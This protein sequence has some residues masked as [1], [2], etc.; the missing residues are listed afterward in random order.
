MKH[1]LIVSIA[2]AALACASVAA[3]ASADRG[4]HPHRG[5]L[6]QFRGEV[7]SASSTGVQVTVEGGNHAALRA[8]LGQPQTETFTMGQGTE[9]LVWH[10]SI[11]TVGSW[12]DLHQNDW[13]Q[14]TIRAAAGSPLSTITATAAGLVGDHGTA[15]GK[16]GKPLYLYRG[17]YTG[18]STASTISVNV[19]GG[20]RR[21]LRTMIGQPATQSFSYDSNTIFLLWQ[22][23]VPTVISASQLKQGDRITVRIRAPR[24]S[25]LQQVEQTPAKHVGEHEPANAPDNA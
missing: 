5:Q 9:V 4:G 23:K 11:P 1:R 10:D 12:S 15:P 8:M 18:S 7:V 17:T 22:G 25:T 19:T 16:A 2:A 21:A 20:N 3:A 14:A 24:D 13:V 6:Y